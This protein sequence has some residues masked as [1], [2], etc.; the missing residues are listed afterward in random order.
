MK[1][2]S[3]LLGAIA[4]FLW[5]SSCEKQKPVDATPSPQASIENLEF[6]PN[7]LPPVTLPPATTKLRAPSTPSP[8][9]LPSTP[10]DVATLTPSELT[11]TLRSGQCISEHKVLHL[12]AEVTPP[13]GD[14]MFAIDLTGSMGGELS[15]VKAN[16]VDIMD[17]IRG[18]IPDTYF[19]VVSHMDYNGFFSGCEYSATY[20]SGSDYPYRL[21]RALTSATSDVASS[22][23]ALVLGF[24][25]DGPE[26]YT[27]IMYESYSDG[28]IGW[29]TGAK[30]IMLAWLDAIPHDCAYD[31]CLG[32]TTHTSGP[33][34]GRDAVV[35][36]GDDLDLA[37]VLAGMAANNVTLIAL[38]SGGSGTLPLWDCYAAKTG[39]DA[40]LINFDGTIPGDI[41]IGTFVA[42]LI[43]EEIKHIDNLSLQVCT[44][45]FE[46][47]L[48]SVTPASYTG[49]DLGVARDFEFDV[50]ICVPAGTANGVYTFDIC[51]IGDGVE[52]AKQKVTITVLN[53]IK[54]PVDV[55]PT[56][57]PNPLNTNDKGVL[58]VAILG[59]PTFDVTQVDPATV[60]LMGVSPIRWALEDVA[61]PYVPF[62]G[63]TNCNECTTQGA[64]GFM[65]LSLKFDAQAI[66]AAL[67]SVADNDC[68]VVK[69]NGQRFDG[70]PIVG[71]DVVL[72]K[73][74]K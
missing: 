23:N 57:C 62:V 25:N 15:N 49:I 53:E 50:T 44:P 16:S 69:L 26:N 54:V 59:T 6:E 13:K 47:W 9:L 7:P 65:D 2:F 3:I 64:D 31:A 63:K 52:Y 1:R 12:P 71:E 33:D 43:K 35:G 8:G 73:K 45:G 55:K 29:R 72:I 34:P 51:A 5:F 27:R 17:A 19:G 30:K 38:F 48:S 58:P 36:T 37:N 74:K 14:I 32:G 22:I 46:S 60:T 56:S 39:G 24:G 21:D 40:I 66:V 61:T 20:G 18:L 42:G 10:P 4:L 41:D 11:A 28:A 68:I 67:G 70:W